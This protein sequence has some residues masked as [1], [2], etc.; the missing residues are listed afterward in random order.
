MISREFQTNSESETFSLGEKFAQN[1]TGGTCV[2]LYGQLGA[3]KTVF[4]RGICNALG[5]GAVRS[6]TF[7]LVN[8]YAGKVAHVDLYRLEG[9]KKSVEN[10]L[11]QE[12]IDDGFILIIEWAQN[13]DFL[14]DK[15]FNVK[16]K[17]DENNENTR[18]FKISS[19]EN[20]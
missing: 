18:V 17:I 6:P 7:T 1:L 5:V 2:L 16:I 3:G 15:I 9:D 10:L 8:E 14:M 13:G 12:Y 20:F 4:V 11:L 19:R